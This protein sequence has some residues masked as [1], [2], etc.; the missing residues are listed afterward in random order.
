MLNVQIL[1]RG[2]QIT[3]VTDNSKYADFTFAL[4]NSKTLSGKLHANN[5]SEKEKKRVSKGKHAYLN[6]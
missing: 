6:E 1:A 4:V 2:Q 5:G 3:G